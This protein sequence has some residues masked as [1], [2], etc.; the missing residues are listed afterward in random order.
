[1]T[2]SSD[3]AQVFGSFVIHL[4]EISSCIYFL[5]LFFSFRF[6]YYLNY[7][8]EESEEEADLE[9]GREW[10]RPQVPG[11]SKKRGRKRKGDGSGGD[12]NDPK[13][14]DVKPEPEDGGEF[15]NEVRPCPD[16]RQPVIPVAGFDVSTPV[17]LSSFLYDCFFP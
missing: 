5:I 9:W 13:K 6:R 14:A 12:P 4:S 8:E 11:S 3:F 1:M 7:N 15:D 16:L 17:I 10:D 2:Y